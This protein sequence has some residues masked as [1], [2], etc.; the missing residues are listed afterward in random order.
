MQFQTINCQQFDRLNVRQERRS[1]Q[2]LSMRVCGSTG[3]N[4]GIIRN[5]T[6]GCLTIGDNN[7]NYGNT[8]Y[9]GGN[10]TGT[11]TA[12]LLMECLDNTEIVVHDYAQRLLGLI[13]YLG[14]VTPTIQ[15]GR[16]K[17]WGNANNIHMEC[18]DWFNVYF[19]N[20]AGGWQNLSLQPT[21]LWGDG[22]STASEYGGT[23]YLTM[24]Q[25]MFQSPHIVP[26]GVGADARIRMGRAGGISTGTWW[27]LAAKTNGNFSI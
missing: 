13:S 4:T 20:G 18:K 21:S 14:G 9:T 15:I 17:G 22:L 1:H 11:N 5:S 12:G 7:T 23:K 25:V 24:R 8:Y 16:D 3:N 26:S 10:W 27:E 6:A 2:H 19:V